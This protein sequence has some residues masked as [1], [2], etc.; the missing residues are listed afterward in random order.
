MCEAISGGTG[1]SLRANESPGAGYR[2]RGPGPL[3]AEESVHI[4]ER[5][6]KL[7]LLA[8]QARARA[9]SLPDNRKGARRSP[10]L[11]TKSDRS[12]APPTQTH[13]C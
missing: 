13:I 4:A 5:V 6:A 3:D 2:N 1:T 7:K 9:S 10:L 8:L 11:S 12:A